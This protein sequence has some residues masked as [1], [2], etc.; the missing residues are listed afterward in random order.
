MGLFSF[1]FFHFV[2]DLVLHV[3][4]RLVI[5]LSFLSQK[6]KFYM[7][8]QMLPGQVISHIVFQPL[9]IVFY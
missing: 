1:S 4:Y 8:T 9:D 5:L 6:K 3:Y 7:F 2:N